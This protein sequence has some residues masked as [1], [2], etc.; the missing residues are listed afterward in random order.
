[1]LDALTKHVISEGFGKKL[2][3]LRAEFLAKAD[4]QT[5]AM[6]YIS[7][8]DLDKV[9]KDIVGQVQAVKGKVNDLTTGA[10]I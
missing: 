4:F 1:M 5:Q 9:K 8:S 10:R 2:K 6:K 7:S 3:E